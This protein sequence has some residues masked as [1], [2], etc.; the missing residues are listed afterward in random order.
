MPRFLTV[1]DFLFPTHPS[2]W[3]ASPLVTGKTEHWCCQLSPSPHS[4]YPHPQGLVSLCTPPAFSTTSYLGL[5][6][7]LWRRWD[8][9]AAPTIQTSRTATTSVYSILLAFLYWALLLL[10]MF[11]WQS[12]PLSSQA[13]AKHSGQFQ[14]ELYSTWILSRTL[15]P[16]LPLQSSSQKGSHRHLQ[17]NIS[18]LVLCRKRPHFS[19]SSHKN[20]F[21]SVKTT[22][23]DP[24][25]IH[26]PYQIV[27]HLL[28]PLP[29]LTTP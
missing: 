24:P 17:V 20:L 26:H 11:S 21:T 23:G 14:S 12:P 5:Q 18:D 9:T 29:C 2:W 19:N 1:L 8:M 3:A 28:H 4:H 7:L 27:Q 6:L 25:H 16:T 10:S 15:P 13:Y 22:W